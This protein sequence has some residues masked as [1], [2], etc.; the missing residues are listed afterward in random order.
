MLA[1]FVQLFTGLIVILSFVATALRIKGNPNGF[2]IDHNEL[3]FDIFL[4]LGNEF[5]GHFFD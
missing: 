5:I 4:N 1:T 2:I 3:I